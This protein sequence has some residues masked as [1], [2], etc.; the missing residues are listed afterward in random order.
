M[1]LSRWYSDCVT[2]IF[3][4]FRAMRTRQASRRN[5]Q[6]TVEYVIVAGV[7]LASLAILTLFLTTFREHGVRVLDLAA[8][9]Y[10]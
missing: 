8:S 9:E 7:L 2:G 3:Y 1:V 6:A 10:P 4:L 5:G